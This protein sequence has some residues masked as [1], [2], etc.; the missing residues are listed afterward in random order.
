M[1]REVQVVRLTKDQYDALVKALGGAASTFVDPTS[2]EGTSG[3]K[4]GVQHV[5]EALRRGWVLE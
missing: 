1:Q 4:L 5:L 3:F 2:T